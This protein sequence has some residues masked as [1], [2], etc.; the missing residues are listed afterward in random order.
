MN[1]LRDGYITGVGAFLPGDPVPNAAVEDHIG[2]VAGRD[3]P[4]GRRALRWNGVRSRQ[5]PPSREARLAVIRAN[6]RV[7]HPPKPG[8]PG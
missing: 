3:S 5:G 4:F 8:T 2:R 1:A 6:V 7:P